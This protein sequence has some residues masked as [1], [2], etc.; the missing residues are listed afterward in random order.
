MSVHIAVVTDVFSRFGVVL[1]R[2]SDAVCG[3][4]FGSKPSTAF[5]LTF[6]IRFEYGNLGYTHFYRVRRTSLQF[7]LAHVYNLSIV[8][9]GVNC[10]LTRYS[11]SMYPENASYRQGKFRSPLFSAKISVKRYSAE[12]CF[13]SM[14]GGW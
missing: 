11:T 4:G 2:F 14:R 3:L 6:M 1:Y 12:C 9:H 7:M 5:L 13:K 8:Q 10:K